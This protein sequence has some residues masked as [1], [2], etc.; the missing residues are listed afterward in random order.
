MCLKHKETL[1]VGVKN[2]CTAV[3]CCIGNITAVN[4]SLSVS[5]LLCGYDR[6]YFITCGGHDSLTDHADTGVMASHHCDV[7]VLSTG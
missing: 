6:S 5:R 3:S 1:K 4:N 7:V 2:W